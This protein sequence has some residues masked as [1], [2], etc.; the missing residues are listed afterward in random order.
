MRKLNLFFGLLVSLLLTTSLSAQVTISASSDG[1]MTGD[2]V[3]IDIIV[4]N[5]TELSAMQFA[6]RWNPDVVTYRDLRNFGLDD[7][8]NSMT[9]NFNF[10]FAQLG[11]GKLRYSWFNDA[12]TLDDGTII[13]TIV[14]DV[15]G[16]LGESTDI[17]VASC[18]DD[19]PPLIIEVG[20][21]DGMAIPDDQIE[22]NNGTVTVGTNS[23]S[24]S[25]T[26]DFTLFQNNPNPFNKETNIRFSLKNHSN[27]HLSIYNY[28]GKMIFEKVAT[29]GSGEHSVS[30]DRSVFPAA[31]TY[32]YRLNTQ[33]S[34]SIRKLIVQ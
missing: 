15:I 12:T 23:T 28:T 22:I 11:E 30:I 6:L 19:N 17:E 9:N 26:Q 16:A 3:E 5:Y 13:F 34:D 10:G 33:N 25:E 8:T 18:P 4:E 7:L 20:D 32:F 29:L 24:E 27:T 31:G 2:T 14:F 1:A 21:A